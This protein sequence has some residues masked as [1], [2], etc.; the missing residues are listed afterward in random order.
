[1]SQHNDLKIS[2]RIEFNSTP[3]RLYEAM[4]NAD[5]FSKV[6]NSHV[7]MNNDPGGALSLFDGMITG[8]NGSMAILVLKIF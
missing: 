3:T 4:V 1:M 6:T 5:Q 2:Q 8:Q 7:E